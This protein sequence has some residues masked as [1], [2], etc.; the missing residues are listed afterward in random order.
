MSNYKILNE[1]LDFLE[2][3]VKAFEA[4]QVGT[5][6]HVCSLKDYIKYILPHDQLSSSG[7]YY[8]YL[9]GG[10]NYVSFTRDQR[11]VI[12]TRDEEYS[13][14]FIQLVVDGNKLSENYK[15]A[16]YN[17]FAYTKGGKLKDNEDPTRREMEECV[18]GPIKNIS[19]YIKEVRF[20]ILA[21]HE[22]TNEPDILT[23][24]KKRKSL[25]NLVY[26][27]FLGSKSANI[28]INSGTPFD[29][30]LKAV[31]K[32]RIQES[33][34]EQLFTYDEDEVKEAIKN[35]A[36][37]NKKHDADGYP[38][39]YYCEDDDSVGIVK[40]LLKAG[41]NPN[42]MADKDTP[43]LCAAIGNLCN[44]I[45]KEL[46]KAG[47]DI[48]QRDSDGLTPL[49][50]AAYSGDPDIVNTLIKADAD[51]NAKD[52]DGDNALQYTEDNKILN[53]LKKAGAEE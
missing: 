19:K 18:K 38:L 22:L 5:L 25:K 34:Q 51:V 23:L 40:L 30:A 17:D 52:S 24:N 27:K 12:D 44:K 7:Q 45:V 53:I 48:E 26:Y 20:D 35:G 2:N 28:G 1:K 8:N 32:W 37:V 47:A 46:I 43:L 13:F 10:N 16:P 39:A 21:T 11:F 4:K 31:D 3:K 29:E 33:L 50:N 15:V 14:V 41:A 42:I 36:D 9:Y 49:M 6:Y